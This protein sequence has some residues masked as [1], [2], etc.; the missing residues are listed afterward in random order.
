LTLNDVGKVLSSG[1]KGAEADKEN[2]RNWQQKTIEDNALKA[3]VDKDLKGQWGFKAATRAFHIANTGYDVEIVGLYKG[4]TP[5]TIKIKQARRVPG[6]PR[7]SRNLFDLSQVLAWLAK[8]RRDV[9]EQL[10][11]R[12]Q[13]PDILNPLNT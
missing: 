12:E 13:I 9:Q 5:T 1:L 6:S 7:R 3:W 2:F 10:E 4:R 8:E 11:W